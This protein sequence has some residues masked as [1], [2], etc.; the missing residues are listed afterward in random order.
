MESL[1]I[2]NSG[3]ILK[4]FTHAVLILANSADPGEMQH[5]AAF[6][7]GLHCLLKYSLR[8]F[9]NTWGKNVHFLTIVILIKIDI[10][11]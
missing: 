3:I 9:Q 6:H 11:Q 8:G 5:C 4:I 1:K 2:L 7:L 10:F